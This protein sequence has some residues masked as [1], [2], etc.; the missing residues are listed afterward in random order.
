[1]SVTRATE[2]REGCS[3]EPPG[4]GGENPLA[5]GAARAEALWP[6]LVQE[7]SAPGCGLHRAEIERSLQQGQCSGSPQDLYCAGFSKSQDGGAQG[8][9]DLEGEDGL[10]GL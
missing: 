10:V 5:G 7:G 8:W 3:L 1:M 6:R 2:E 9:V 4:G